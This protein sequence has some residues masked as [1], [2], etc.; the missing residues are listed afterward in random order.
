MKN[1]TNHLLSLLVLAG[2]ALAGCSSN[3]QLISTMDN[4][5]AADTTS[6]QDVGVTDTGTA[7]TTQDTGVADTADTADTGGGEQG[8]PAVI[9]C[10]EAARTLCDRL[11]DCTDQA[12]DLRDKLEQSYGFSDAYSCRIKL[13]HQMAGFCQP[14]ALS[15]QDAR[16]TYHPAAAADCLSQLQSATCDTVFQGLPAIRQNDL[17]QPAF[18]DDIAEA[19]QA[20]FDTCLADSDCQGDGAFCQGAAYTDSTVQQGT[21]ATRGQAGT[22]CSLPQDCADGLYCNAGTCATLPAEGDDCTSICQAG[23]VCNRQLHQCSPAGSLGDPCHQ[24]S[25]CQS[26][27]ACDG[28]NQCATAPGDGEHCYERCAAGL[29][30]NFQN[31][32]CEPLP[33]DGEDCTSKCAAGLTCGADF[34]CKPIASEGDSCA[35]AECTDGLVCTDAD[36]TCT[37]PAVVGEACQ[38]DSDCIWYAACASDHTCQPRPALGEP[39]TDSC[40]EP[41]V[42]SGGT[43]V[44]PSAM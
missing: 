34:T 39:C 7:D 12:A 8:P 5:D 2:V 9:Y 16:A 31:N 13:S 18:C 10:A 11:Y 29:T 22:S 19:N 4:R 3:S 44:D 26:D 41:S 38:Q 42:C 28:T 15:A 6:Q 37:A 27:L 23:L 25:D 40:V 21:C 43:C 14:A 1:G 20:A 30:C 32:T 17:F 33:G 35:N 36:S 24:A